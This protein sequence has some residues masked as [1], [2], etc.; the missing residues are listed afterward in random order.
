MKRISVKTMSHV[1]AVIA[2]LTLYL[3]LIMGFELPA[4]VQQIG[5]ALLLLFTITAGVLTSYLI[6]SSETEQQSIHMLHGD[7]RNKNQVE[8]RRAA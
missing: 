2:A 5:S 8:S 7:N 4:P 3:S 1:Y 6:N